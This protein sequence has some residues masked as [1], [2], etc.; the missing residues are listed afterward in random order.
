MKKIK[1]IT[2]AIAILGFTSISFAQIQTPVGSGTVTASARILKTLTLT[3]TAELR[4]GSIIRNAAEGVVTVG[5][6]GAA[7]RS[8]PG[9]YTDLATGADDHGAAAFTIAGSENATYVL[10]LPESVV[11]TAAGTPTGTTT[12]TAN[13][14]TSNSITSNTTGK[15]NEDGE[16]ALLVGADLNVKAD[17]ATAIYT[18]T[19]AITVA[20]N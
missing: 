2:L 9:A 5:V 19:F 12:M 14:F 11:L 3:K 6:T 18:G 7:V 4:F 13:N 1:F 17:Q 20:Y 15:L 16:F 10:T 8:L